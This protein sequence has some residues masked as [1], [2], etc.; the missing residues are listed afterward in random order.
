[1][2]H[3][4]VERQRDIERRVEI[5]VCRDVRFWLVFVVLIGSNCFLGS[6]MM[7]RTN[8]LF[9]RPVG[10]VAL[11]LCAAGAWW[12]T[13]MLWIRVWRRN[14]FAVLGSYKLCRNCGYDLRATVE[15]CPECGT[16]ISITH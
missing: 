8:Q 6:V 7:E 2:E 16:E 12:I 15:R 10:L 14:A 4:P 9:G 1:M 5:R 13:I 3:L 11:V